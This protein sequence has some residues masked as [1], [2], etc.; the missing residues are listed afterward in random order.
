[1][2]LPCVLQRNAKAGA[3]A[4]TAEVYIEK[5]TFD[6][7]DSLVMTLEYKNNFSPSLSLFCL[8]VDV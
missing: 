6:F 7:L 2:F 5:L 1:M 4:N 8:S 3:A